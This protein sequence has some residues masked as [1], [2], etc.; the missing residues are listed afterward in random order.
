M[1]N[2]R[3]ADDCVVRRLLFLNPWLAPA[4]I[5]IGRNAAVWGQASKGPEKGQRTEGIASRQ[6]D[7]CLAWVAKT[8]P[9]HL[10]RSGT[11][12]R[13]LEASEISVA[14]LHRAGG[15]PLLRHT[16]P[17]WPPMSSPN[18][19]EVFSRFSTHSASTRARRSSHCVP[20]HLDV[21]RWCPLLLTLHLPVPPLGNPWQAR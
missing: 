7:V 1:S 8:G 11:R 5:C 16:P 2:S 6:L 20:L 14:L 9:I 19:G 3:R 13:R 12:C 21:R 10:P 4:M 17:P 18:S 15:G